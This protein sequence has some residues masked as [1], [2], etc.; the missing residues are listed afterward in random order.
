MRATA[1]QFGRVLLIGFRPQWCGQPFGTFKVLFNAMLFH[2]E[3]T[4]GAS[5]APDFWSKPR[6][7]T[8][9]REVEDVR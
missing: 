7:D 2:G 1:A 5:G 9:E 4:E 6:T 8:N 3:I